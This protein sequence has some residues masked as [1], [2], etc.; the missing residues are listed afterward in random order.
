M[1]DPPKPIIMPLLLA[2]LGELWW[3]LRIPLWV[4]GE[5]EL[6]DWNWL[7]PRVVE[8]E[9]SPGT[10]DRCDI[11]LCLTDGTRAIL[12]ADASAMPNCE[13]QGGISE[14]FELRM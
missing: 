8:A 3:K 9:T 7:T 4:V 5:S 2:A 10:R 11:R 14:A 13:Q 6:S 12:C 1:L